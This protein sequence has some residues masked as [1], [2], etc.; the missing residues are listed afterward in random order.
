MIK[1]PQE[2]TIKNVEKLRN[3]RGNT[4]VQHLIEGEELK[5]KAK[6]ISKLTLEPGASIGV[7]EHKEDFEV[8]YILQ[9]EGRVMDNGHMQPIGSGDV[10]YTANGESHCLE[11]T[12]EGNLVLL[13][14]VINE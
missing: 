10:V 14:I 6:L 7:H 8:Y 1:R 3:G 4:I 13:D 12:G 9:G 11:N 5:G 2:L